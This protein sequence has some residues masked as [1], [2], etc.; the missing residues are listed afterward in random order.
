[1]F[2][3]ILAVCI[4]FSGCSGELQKRDANTSSGSKDESSGKSTI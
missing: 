2:V 4:I 3:K 1:M